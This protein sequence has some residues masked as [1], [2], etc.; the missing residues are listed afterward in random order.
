M[1]DMGLE[2]IPGSASTVAG[3]L[4]LNK[5]LDP[6]HPS[7]GV[8]GVPDADVSTVAT[9]QYKAVAP[10]DNSVA[11]LVQVGGGV[12]WDPTASWSFVHYVDWATMRH[13]I[14]KYQ[15]DLLGPAADSS[16][17]VTAIGSGDLIP[18]AETWYTGTTG[19]ES[20]RL[21]YAGLTYD[22]SMP[23]LADQGRAVAAQVKARYEKIASVPGTGL[24][25]NVSSD[26]FHNSTASTVNGTSNFPDIARWIASLTTLDERSMTAPAKLGAYFP[27]RWSDPVH[28]YVTCDGTVATSPLTIAGTDRAVYVLPFVI[29]NVTATGT[30]YAP[31]FATETYQSVMWGEDG[32]IMPWNACV[33]SVTGLGSDSN[34]QVTYRY[35]LETQLTPTGTPGGTPWIPF[36]H[37]IPE[38]DALALEVA[39]RIRTKM[40]S[41]FPADYNFLDKLWGMVKGVASKVLPSVLPAVGSMIPGIGP[42]AGPALGNLAGA[43]FPRKPQ[44]V[45]RDEGYGGQTN[46]MAELLKT[47]L[48]NMNI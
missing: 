10:L 9:P 1:A 23:T 5:V 18:T 37:A 15:G 11:G 12:D 40:D 43:L 34:Y 3:S 41:A 35:G 30:A 46:P 8:L 44:Q 20:L 31:G 2:E 48:G 7:M 27:V 22:P 17:W 45:V 28:T 33:Y 32:K 4:W 14:I 39:D 13:C 21:L 47:L 24:S 19:I 25:G 36:T 29:N 42:I 26:V 6:C 38:H 16:V